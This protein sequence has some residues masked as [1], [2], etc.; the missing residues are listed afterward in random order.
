MLDHN[1]MEQVFLNLILNAIQAMDGKSGEL[2]IE[3]ASNSGYCDISFAD[4][5]P[6]IPAK[7]LP[8][9]FDPFLLQSP[10]VKEQV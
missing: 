5:G 6:G 7:V 2:T 9:I 4:T 10:W 8:H 1:K 3:T